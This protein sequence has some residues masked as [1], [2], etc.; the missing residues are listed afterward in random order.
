[1]KGLFYAAGIGGV[2]DNAVF[3]AQYTVGYWNHFCVCMIQTSVSKQE[4]RDPGTDN[5]CPVWGVQTCIGINCHRCGILHAIF[6]CLCSGVRWIPYSIERFLVSI[7]KI[8]L[9]KEQALECYSYS[10]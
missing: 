7:T 6:T 5:S 8:V 1:M 4:S 3:L 10:Y 9:V 2:L